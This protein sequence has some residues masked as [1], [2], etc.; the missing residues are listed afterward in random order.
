MAAFTG[1]AT[2][3]FL[4]LAWA[5]VVLRIVH[6][7]IHCTYNRVMHRFTAYLLSSLVLWVI[8]VYLA[9]QLLAQ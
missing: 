7:F 8:W 1:V 4:A 9:L 2:G 3:V 6:S 5:F